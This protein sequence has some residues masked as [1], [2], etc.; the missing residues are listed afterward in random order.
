MSDFCRGTIPLVCYVN[1]F[2]FF[3]VGYTFSSR[4]VPT[5]R[6]TFGRGREFKTAF[7]NIH[8]FD[9]RVTQEKEK[10]MSLV[11]YKRRGRFVRRRLQ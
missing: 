1:F 4:A 11:A 8:D 10:W 3:C 9:G 2:Q 5:R 6:R 7:T